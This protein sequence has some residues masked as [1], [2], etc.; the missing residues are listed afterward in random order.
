MR[1]LTVKT[2][3]V[4]ISARCRELLSVHIGIPRRMVVHIPTSVEIAP[5]SETEQNRLEDTYRS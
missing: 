4:W 1:D 5:Y 2:W 3:L